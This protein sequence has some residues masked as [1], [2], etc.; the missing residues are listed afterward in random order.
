QNFQ[1]N[2]KFMI[3]LSMTSIKECSEIKSNRKLINIIAD[4]LTCPITKQIT[5]DF[6]ILTCGHSISCYAI[7]KWR[8]TITI[9]N[10]PF[11]CPFCRIDIDLNSTYN[12][13][14]NKILEGLYEKLEQQG[15]FNKLSEERQILPNKTYMVEDNLFLKFNKYKIF[16]GSILSK[17][18]APIFQKVQPKVMLPAFNKAAKAELQK[19]HEAVIMWLKTIQLNINSNHILSVTINSSFTNTSKKLFN[20]M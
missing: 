9:E 6:L 10:R 16:Q 14:K 12:L 1:L 5:G 8:E 18:S 4:N 7:N 3:P 13:P 19:D 20:S 15:Y 17:F 2:L 11:E